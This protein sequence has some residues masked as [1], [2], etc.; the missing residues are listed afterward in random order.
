MWYGQ[1]V[2]AVIK[3]KVGWRRGIKCRCYN[4]IHI[5]WV[6]LYI[7]WSLIIGLRGPSSRYILFWVVY[8]QPKPPRPSPAIMT[9]FCWSILMP[10]VDGGPES[11]EYSAL[12]E[13]CF[14]FRLKFNDV[15][16][17][18]LAFMWF[19]PEAKQTICIYRK[20]TLD[21][22]AKNINI[23]FGW[24]FFADRKCSFCFVS[25]CFS[26]FVHNFRLWSPFFL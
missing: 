17:Y 19:R 24:F 16:C 4:F 11:S 13:E 14:M 26:V 7:C 15:I 8:H 23:L 22:I 25:I 3:Y 18:D 2:S 10:N 5:Q 21:F 6:V 1:G 9:F 20:Q 12:Y